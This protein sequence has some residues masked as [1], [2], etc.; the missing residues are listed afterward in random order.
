[1]AAGTLLSLVPSLMISFIAG[2]GAWGNEMGMGGFDG[3]VAKGAI[4]KAAECQQAAEET[5]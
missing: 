1:M 2:L 3:A 4:D 5:R